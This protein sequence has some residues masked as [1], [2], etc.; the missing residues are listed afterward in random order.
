M[1]QEISLALGSVSGFW[2][3]HSWF[4]AQVLAPVVSYLSCWGAGRGQLATRWPSLLH[5]HIGMLEKLLIYL[6]KC[7]DLWQDLVDLRPPLYSP[8]PLLP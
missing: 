5:L 6:S 2:A 1:T 8:G 7:T 4:L 3:P